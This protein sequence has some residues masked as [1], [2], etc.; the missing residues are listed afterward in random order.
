LIGEINLYL[1]DLTDSE[2]ATLEAQI[3]LEKS[4]S[5]VPHIVSRGTVNGILW[6]MRTGHPWRF[7]PTQYGH[8]CSI[9]RRFQDWSERGV[10]RAITVALA[11]TRDRPIDRAPPNFEFRQGVAFDP[12]GSSLPSM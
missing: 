10:W 8:W 6:R 3:E 11:K 5:R 2:W 7:I 9:R 12:E 1:G 4:S